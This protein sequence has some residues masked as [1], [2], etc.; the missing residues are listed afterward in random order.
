M[1]T[2]LLCPRC[3]AALATPTPPPPFLNCSYCGATVALAGA[4]PTVG[5]SSPEAA[6][7]AKEVTERT[8][9]QRFT[10]SVAASM[11]AA[12]SPYD[13]IRTSADKHLAPAG[14]GDV[15]AKVAIALAAD[16]DAANKCAA[17]ADAQS[18]ARIALAYH[19]VIPELRD[20]GTASLTL[21]FLLATPEGP[22]HFDRTL[23]PAEATALYQRPAAA[24]KKRG[25]WP[26][27]G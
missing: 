26:F 15:I 5:P 12:M 23:T 18:L 13:A 14:Q 22:V 25:W 16:F 10:E 11:K 2:A 8:P 27:G 21:P 20:R 17:S 1:T 24:P 7:A 6:Q 19:G 4:Q 9:A 3:G